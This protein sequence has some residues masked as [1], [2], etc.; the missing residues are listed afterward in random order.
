MSVAVCIARGA[1]WDAVQALKPV[2]K[3]ALAILTWPGTAAASGLPE[4]PM[5][6]CAS[7]TALRHTRRGAADTQM[8][9]LLAVQ[10]VTLHTNLGDL[11]LEVYCEEVPRAAENFLALCASGFYNGTLFH[12]NIRGFMIQG[13]DPTGAQLYLRMVRAC[14]SRNEKRE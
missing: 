10:A 12:R 13:G 8:L 7:A 11:K 9:W 2:L 5:A 1:Y 3:Q 14:Y 4:Q 6:W